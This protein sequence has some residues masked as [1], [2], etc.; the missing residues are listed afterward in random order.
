MKY[1]LYF[2]IL[3]ALGCNSQSSK[4][5]IESKTMP[6]IDSFFNRVS[7]K[8]YS[9]AF[10]ELLKSNPDIN[11]EDSLTVESKKNFLYINNVAGVFI[12]YHLLKKRFISEDIAVYTYLA[13]YEKKYF[14]FFFMFYNNGKIIQLYKFRFDDDL[15]SELE[16]SLQ[17]YTN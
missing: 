1:I 10:D 4:S 8:E 13:K 5:R 17:Y 11:I 9:N 7:N 16:A 2:S 6:I 12:E 3:I 15:A 14:R